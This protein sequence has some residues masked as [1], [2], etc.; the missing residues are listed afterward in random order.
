MRGRLIFQFTAEL[1]RLDTNAIEV[2][3]DYDHTFR[4]VLKVDNDGDGIGESQRQEHTHDMIPCQVEPQTWEGLRAHDL[5]NNLEIDVALVFHFRD[6]ERLSLVAPDG[7]PLISV[8]D[9]LV[10]IW[11]RAGST[12]VQDVRTPPGLYVTEATPI[13]YGLDLANPSRNLLLVTF[14]QRGIEA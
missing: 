1:A 3:G 10:A 14:Q 6:L 12:K 7:N 9:R 5:G 11:N 4:E 8:G 2:A 13:G